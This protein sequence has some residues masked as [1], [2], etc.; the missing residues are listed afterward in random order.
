[1]LTDIQANVLLKALRKRFDLLFKNWPGL[2]YMVLGASVDHEWEGPFSP[3]I[4][5]MLDGKVHTGV[6]EIDIEPLDES[7]EDYKL[8]LFHQAY[9]QLHIPPEPVE[10][11]RFRELG[12]VKIT[13][14]L[15]ECK[16]ISTKEAGK[17]EV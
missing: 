12:D 3:S 11:L 8:G 4:G 2:E 6:W 1:M 15:S 7:D 16:R 14:R 13:R 5:I 17:Y 10:N 9:S